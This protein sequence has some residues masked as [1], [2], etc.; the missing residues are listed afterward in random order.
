MRT[1]LVLMLV[2]LAPLVDGGVA[3]A[4]PPDQLDRYHIVSRRSTFTQSG[5]FGGIEQS[6]PLTGRYGFAQEWR[7]NPRTGLTRTAR[8]VEPDLMAPLGPMLP[9]FIDVDDLLNLDNLRSELLPLGAPFDVYRFRGIAAD[10]AAASPLEQSTVELFAALQG[11]WMYLYGRTTPPP[12]TADRFVYEIQALART[13][14]WADWNDD[15]IVDAADYTLMRDSGDY[16]AEMYT[17][18]RSQFG[19]VEPDF[20]M[21]AAAVS[22]SMSTPPI[23]EPTSVSTL[24]AGAAALLARRRSRA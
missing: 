7:G 10:S 24:V 5:G 6:F 23:P 16:S 19:E 4:Q 12:S 17:D 13:R 20:S 3:W 11:P 22:A 14:P 8:F 9:A 2:V 18:W 1:S 15:G 21:L